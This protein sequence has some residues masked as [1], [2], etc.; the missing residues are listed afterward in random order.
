MSCQFIASLETAPAVVPRTAVICFVSFAGFSSSLVTRHQSK[1]CTLS[2]W[3]SPPLVAL[4]A[5]LRAMY[6]RQ[7]PSLF[8]TSS[9]RCTFPFPHGQDTTPQLSVGHI[10]LTQLTAV[11][12]RS[13]QGLRSVERVCLPV[14]IMGVA[15]CRFLQTVRP[16]L[17]F[18]PRPISL[19]G[20]FRLTRCSTL[21]I[22]STFRCFPRP[23][24]P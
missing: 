14:G 4:S 8:P 7:R 12:M 11:E 5:P 20:R 6:H 16:T 1:V 24:P 13:G 15:A 22:C 17:P 23:L 18:W 19:F 10:G 2:G 3:V 9:T 21:H